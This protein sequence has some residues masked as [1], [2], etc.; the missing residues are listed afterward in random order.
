MNEI[1]LKNPMLNMLVTF[2]NQGTRTNR[3]TRRLLVFCGCFVLGV[4]PRYVVAETATAK[5]AVKSSA[6]KRQTWQEMMTVD[7]NRPVAEL[8]ALENADQRREAFVH[9]NDPEQIEV[10]AKELFGLWDTSERRVAYDPSGRRLQPLKAEALKQFRAKNYQGSLDAFRAY[11]FAKMRLLF[12][13]SNGYTSSG[14]ENRLRNETLSRNY[15]DT[16]KLLM[17]NIHQVANTKETVHIGEP[18]LV[19]W[20]FVPA[21][22]KL[23]EPPT[24]L[25][26]EYFGAPFDRLWWKFVDTRDQTYLDKYLAFL[27]DYVLNQSFQEDLNIGN[28][29]QGKAGTGNAFAYLHSLAELAK[30]LPP[31]GSG[32]SAASLA[33]MLVRLLSVEIPQSLYYNREQSN[34]HSCGAIGKQILLADYLLDFKLANVLETETRRQFEAYGTLFDMPDG[35]MPVRMRYNNAELRW[36]LDFFQTINDFGFD[37]LTRQQ[38]RE[39]IDR[40]SKRAAAVLNLFNANGEC[41]QLYKA[42]R[43]NAPFDTFANFITRTLP[44]TWNDTAL[45][46]IAARIIHNQQEPDWRGKVYVSPDSPAAREAF[47]VA[48]GAEPPYAS[49]SFPYVGTHVLRSG[50]DPDRDAYGIFVESDGGGSVHGTKCANSLFIGGFGHDVTHTGHPY[51]YNYVQSPVLVDGRDQFSRLT[52]G[53]EGRKGGKNLGLTKLR[54]TRIHH[55]ARFDVVE[56][57][58]DEHWVKSMDHDPGFYDYKYRLKLLKDAITGVSHRRVV[59]FIKQP[60]VWVV[61]DIMNSEPGTRNPEPTHT[62]TQQ[63]FVPEKEGKYTDGYLAQ[64]FAIDQTGKSLRSTSPERANLSIHYAGSAAAELDIKPVR[65]KEEPE[66][67]YGF[68]R[69]DRHEGA[70]FLHLKSEWTTTDASLLITVLQVTNPDGGGNPITGFDRRDDGFTATL[71]SGAKIQCAAKLVESSNANPAVFDSKLTFTSANGD[72]SSIKLGTESY[73][74]S[75]RG[76]SSTSKTPIHTPLPELSILPECNVFIDSLDVTIAIPVPDTVIHYT[77]DGS[78]PTLDSPLYEEPIHLTGSAMVKARAFRPNLTEMPADQTSGVLMTRVFTAVYTR[79]VPIPADE[80]AADKL[81]PGLNYTQ[82]RDKWPRLLFDISN[83]APFKKGEAKGLFDISAAADC[84][85]PFAFAYEGYLE[86]PKDGVYTIHAPTE[87]TH[88]RPLAGY[89]LK[90]WLGRRVTYA[91]VSQ[92]PAEF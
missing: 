18:G 41:V 69:A 2:T 50:W 57:L 65:R 20:D 60:G 3:L 84:K 56:G 14:F 86:V 47:G 55:S 70:P 59:Q 92:K 4:T 13:D 28:I 10:L 77:V 87:F 64:E 73:E 76:L 8:P 30:V 62:C 52:D 75:E 15:G 51:Q 71:V 78:D 9:R 74:F 11:F 26:F 39:Y 42:D 68:F 63:F 58:Y 45:A 66:D 29:D 12:Q 91:M 17:D 5:A 53:P 72:V 79:E 19:R 82:F 54:P 33:R 90:V 24:P 83:R 67:E 31:D 36:N 32:Y 40:L 35:D 6:P 43:R 88:F 89:D 61:Y 7:M 48:A 34:N 80:V 49:I 27:D 1:T 16:V 46:K 25:A 85:G 21:G 23:W 22:P 44:E 81:K 38:R 37:W